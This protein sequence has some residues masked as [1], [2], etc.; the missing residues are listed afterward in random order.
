[1]LLHTWAGLLLVAMA[2]VTMTTVTMTT[3]AMATVAIFILLA[4]I[5]A[6]SQATPLQSNCDVKLQAK[7]FFASEKYFHG[8][9]DM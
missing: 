6:E 4:A 5:A 7:Y 3:I 9:N 2:T 8:I 1:M